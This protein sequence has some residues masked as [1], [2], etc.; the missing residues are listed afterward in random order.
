MGENFKLSRY[1]SYFKVSYFYSCEL[2]LMFANYLQ[3]EGIYSITIVDPEYLDL[4]YG[5]KDYFSIGNPTSVTL[6]TA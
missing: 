1:V 5:R 4:R 6:A 3:R 2:N